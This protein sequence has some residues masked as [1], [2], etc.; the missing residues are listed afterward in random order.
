MKELFEKVQCAISH[1]NEGVIHDCIK[2]VKE[3]L[4]HEKNKDVLALYN[5]VTYNTW[6]DWFCSRF[7]EAGKD[8][9][10]SDDIYKLQNFLSITNK[11]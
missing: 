6:R 2:E 8:W 10:E 11:K 1:I 9:K 5:E 7:Y 3:R 4:K